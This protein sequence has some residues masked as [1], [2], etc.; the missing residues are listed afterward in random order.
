MN[1]SDNKRKPSEKKDNLKVVA[2]AAA[3]CLFFIMVGLLI[4]GLQNV[5][6]DTLYVDGCKLVKGEQGYSIVDYDEFM[7]G[8]KKLTIP[9]HVGGVPVVSISSWAF[10]SSNI[11]EIVLPASL[12]EIE[13]GA[14]GWCHTLESIEFAENSKLASIGS[15]AFY[16]CDSLTSIEIPDSVI[17]IGDYAFNRCD[18]LTSIEIPDSVTSIGEN[19]FSDTNL[20][21]EENGVSYV[22]KWVINCDS[23]LKQVQLRDNTAGIANSAFY[24]CSSLTSIEIPDGVRSIGDSAFYYCDLLVSITIPDSVTSIGYSAFSDCSS[25]TSIVIPDGVTSIGDETFRSCDSLTSIEI[26]D[27]VTSIGEEAFAWCDSLT[28]IEI[29]DG[30]RSIGD[31][32]FLGTNLIQKENGVSYVD[33]WVIDCDGSLK[34]VQLRD[35]TVGIADSAFDLCD[36]TSIIIPDSVTNIGAEA[37]YLCD[38]LKTINFQ[39]TKA[40]WEAVNKGDDWNDFVGGSRGYTVVCTDATLHEEG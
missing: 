22:D 15:S 21:R 25:L 33:K 10:A 11:K 8:K 7:C 19:A 30:V 14:F 2:F 34:Q 31:R 37:F 23:S 27:S 4:A 32:A 12:L 38:S 5:A 35:N 13:H 28:S 29:P 39:G 36:L 9:E 24:N 3:V 18:S 26:P 1:H 17:I 20:V 16:Y 40:Q 6:V